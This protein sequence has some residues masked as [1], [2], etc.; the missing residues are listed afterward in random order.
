MFKIIIAVVLIFG[1]EVKGQNIIFELRDSRTNLLIRTATVSSN[2]NRSPVQADKQGVYSLLEPEGKQTFDIRDY[3]YVGQEREYLVPSLSD[4]PLRVKLLLQLKPLPVANLASAN[5]LEE[6]EAFDATAPINVITYEDI[7]KSSFT[8]L[9]QVLQYLTASINSNRQVIADGTDHIDPVSL[10]GF[11]PDQLLILVNGKRRHS[12]ALVNINN[13]FGRG[14]VSTDLNTI[15]LYLIKKV[16]VLRGDA[17]SLYGSDAIAGV[18]NIVLRNGADFTLGKGGQYGGKFWVDGSYQRGSFRTNADVGFQNSNKMAIQDGQTNAFNLSVGTRIASRGFVTVGLMIDNRHST[19]RAGFDTRPLLYTTEP[20]RLST[21]TEAA[22]EARFRGLQVKDSARAVT[23]ELSRRNIR[24][25]LAQM[26]TVALMLNGE[27]RVGQSTV[28]VTGGYSEKQG[29]GAG[30]YRL[31]RQKTQMD[32]VLYPNGFLPEIGSLIQDVSAVV[33]VRGILSTKRYSNKWSYDISNTIGSNR[34]GFMV[35]N[36]TNASILG[37]QQTRFDAGRLS[38]LQN[39]I[40]GNIINSVDPTKGVFEHYQWGLGLEYRY[41]RYG[42]N[43]GEEKSWSRGFPDNP[44]YRGSQIPGA[45]VFPGFKPSNVVNEERKSIGAYLTGEG[46]FGSREQTRVEGTVRLENYNDF[47]TNVSYKL[48]FRQSLFNRATSS[49][50]FLSLDRLNLRGSYTTGFR[51]PS[52]HQRW[53]NKESTQNIGGNL[54]QIQTIN[55]AS[56]IVKTLGL[57]NLVAETSENF[58]VGFAG[59]GIGQRFLFS[60]DGY[61]VKVRNRIVFSGQFPTSNPTIRAAVNNP[62]IN[63][64]QLFTNA[65]NTQTQGVEAQLTGNSGLGR[66]QRLEYGTLFSLNQTKATLQASANQLFADTTL[67]NALFDRQERA[68]VERFVPG[69]KWVLHLSYNLLMD[70]AQP[71][72][73]LRWQV[74]RFGEVTYLEPGPFGVENGQR[75]SDQTFNGR[76]VQNVALLLRLGGVHIQVGADNVFDVYPDKQYIN[77]YNRADNLASTGGYTGALDNTSNGNVIYSRT[78]TQFGANGRFVYGKL[79]IMVGSIQKK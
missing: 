40:N 55:N 76:W 59:V 19:N 18:I 16:E 35:L 75:A 63:S 28:Y 13:T 67:R 65:I 25:G 11:G 2:R 27:L 56:P 21:E 8:E 12:S 17:A 74:V 71:W 66:Q 77:P 39:T 15:P 29:N 38:F 10:R 51:A 54:Q 36:S 31:P 14:S 48:A 33:G 4:E 64:I 72:L 3:S 69:S 23:N 73:T 44:A 50:G 42:I 7:I 32:S 53:F 70:D 57:S 58:S 34:F 60:L 22:Y 52:L 45:Q 47:G 49:H 61:W 41:E 79:R 24:A 20:I 5:A 37:N 9:A 68:R 46:S 30:F 1:I 6:R 62:L 43:A 78:V 26:Q